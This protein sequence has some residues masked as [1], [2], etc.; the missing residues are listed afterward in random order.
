MK[1]VALSA[2][3]AIALTAV[4]AVAHVSTTKAFALS[5]PKTATH[6][7]SLKC[8]LHVGETLSTQGTKPN[9]P[10]ETYWANDTAEDEQELARASVVAY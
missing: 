2:T 10:C 9:A 5:V 3:C 6:P 4:L 7:V 1:N 8:A